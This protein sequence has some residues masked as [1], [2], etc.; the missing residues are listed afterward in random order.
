M[1]CWIKRIPLTG[2][3]WHLKNYYIHLR[4]I[5]IKLFILKPLLSL[6]SS[7]GCSSHEYYYRKFHIFYD[8]IQKNWIF[9]FCYSRAPGWSIEMYL[10]TKFYLVH[11]WKQEF[12]WITIYKLAFSFMHLWL[13]KWFWSISV[14]FSR[15]TRSLFTNFLFD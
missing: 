2:I 8:Q 1:K 12:L 13:L 7:C 6:H 5:K 14:T 4:I 11:S 15:Y 3:R 10:M 9:S